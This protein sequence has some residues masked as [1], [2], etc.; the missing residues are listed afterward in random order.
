MII[1][2]RIKIMPFTYIFYKYMRRALFLYAPP[3]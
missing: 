2:V 1:L 3:E